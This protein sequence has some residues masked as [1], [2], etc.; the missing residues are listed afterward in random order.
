[1]RQFQVQAAL[2][3]QSGQARGLARLGSGPTSNRGQAAAVEGARVGFGRCAV[4]V[5]V[6]HPDNVEH[7]TCWSS[8][9]RG[10]AGYAIWG[11][12]SQSQRG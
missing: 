6:S 8:D 3:E 1:M 7:G 4:K 5:C 11:L 2:E 12:S 10:A 9:R